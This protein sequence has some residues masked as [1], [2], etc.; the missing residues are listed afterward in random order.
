MTNNGGADAF[1]SHDGKFVYYTKWEQRGIWRKPVQGGPETL[2]IPKGTTFYWGLF[3]EGACLL[4]LDAA[5]GPTINCL[6]FGFDRMM[7]VSTLPKGTRINYG[8]PAF[9]VS[10]DGRWILYV[11]LERSESDIVIVEQL[12]IEADPH[13]PAGLTRGWGLGTGD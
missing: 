11:S 8:G 12:P 3:D 6:D 9:S 5:A 2:V 4:D 7:T 10:H 1:E 13:Q